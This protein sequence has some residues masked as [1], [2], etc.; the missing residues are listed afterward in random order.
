VEPVAIVEGPDG[1]L[2]WADVEGDPIRWADEKPE[3]NPQSGNT[4]PA[5]E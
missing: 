2:W 4:E 5:D 3:D 1:R